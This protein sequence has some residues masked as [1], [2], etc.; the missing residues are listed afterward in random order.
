MVLRRLI[1]VLAMLALSA[2]FAS[3][4]GSL[5]AAQPADCCAN[6]MCPMRHMAEA[7][8]DMD[9]GH[10]TP[11]L[12]TCPTPQ[13]RDVSTLVFVR[14]AAPELVAG[15]RSIERLSLPALMVVPM[16]SLEVAAPPPRT[17]LA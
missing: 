5:W 17:T 10:P 13:S 9:M 1:A 15:E 11:Q 4:N 6:G 8:C 16:V 7:H 12:Q 2:A 14:V 3:A